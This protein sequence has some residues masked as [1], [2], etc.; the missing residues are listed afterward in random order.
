MKEEQKTNLKP[1]IGEEWSY[2]DTNAATALI[3]YGV[4]S[5]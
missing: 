3:D 4:S 1:E 2:V 5:T